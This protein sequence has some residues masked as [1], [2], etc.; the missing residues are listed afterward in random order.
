M[1]FSAYPTTSTIYIDKKRALIEIG[2]IGTV[3]INKNPKGTTVKIE[4][5][6]LT[7]AKNFIISATE[8][9]FLNNLSFKGKQKAL[10][11]L[12]IK[13]SKQFKAF[14]NVEISTLKYRNI[15]AEEI[16]IN[17][18]VA[19]NEKLKHKGYIKIKEI[20]TGKLNSE[21]DIQTTTDNSVLKLKVNIKSNKVKIEPFYLTLNL[22]KR[23]I[24]SSKIKAYA[25]TDIAK[26][27]ANLKISGTEKLINILGNMTV[28]IFDGYLKIENIKLILGKLP[29]LA[30]DI[31][32]RHIN[33]KKLTDMTDFGRVTGFVEGYVKDLKLVNFKNPLEF[34]MLVKTENV[35]GVSKRI[36]LK[37]VNSI[38]K[39]GGGIASVAIPFFK[40][41]A[42][43]SIGFRATLKN[44]IFS[45]HG[46]YKEGNK[47]YIVKKGFLV[48]VSV[49]N[50]N[51]NNK[52][53]WNDFLNRIKRVMKKKGGVKE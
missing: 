2:N 42:Y 18:A 21:I 23:E 14:L 7:A 40:N 15:E 5:D 28:R 48:G 52:I 25:N 36:S 6:N 27:S 17:T 22:A 37:A 53:E 46:L 3:D 41:F 11:L 29:I 10:I 32:F 8:N 9:E 16:K 45:L 26:A 35:K 12:N 20:K 47:E 4:S 43:S 1:D 49:I 33:L 34:E 38:S 19:L 39:V 13:N 31:T 44:N 51:S 24:E 30:C 50:M